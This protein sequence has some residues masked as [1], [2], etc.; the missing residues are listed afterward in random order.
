MAA[1]RLGRS[2]GRTRRWRRKGEAAAAASGPGVP[3][4]CWA[5][6][7]VQAVASAFCCSCHLPLALWD[8][9]WKVLLLSYAPCRSARLHACSIPNPPCP[10]QG[11]AGA[12]HAAVAAGAGHTLC[13]GPLLQ[14]AAAR[15]CAAAHLLLALLPER[16]LCCNLL[17]PAGTSWLDCCLLP[18]YTTLVAVPRSRPT[19]TGSSLTSTPTTTRGSTGSELKAC[20]R[21]GMSDGMK[22]RMKRMTKRCILE[23][24]SG[25][26]PCILRP[27]CPFCPQAI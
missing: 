3:G 20:C 26:L 5:D 4:G 11:G 21:D 1:E 13:G 6:L 7:P 27:F 15:A 14:P 10:L 2:S 16:L 22:H 17:L 9:Q 24:Y 18:Y 19:A 23:V 25:S 12:A 8:I